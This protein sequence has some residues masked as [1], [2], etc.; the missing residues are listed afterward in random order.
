[1]NNEFEDLDK[2]LQILEETVDLL[3][4]FMKQLEKEYAIINSVIPEAD[5]PKGP[6]DN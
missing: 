3:K 6:F 5:I 4:D 2:E 1:M